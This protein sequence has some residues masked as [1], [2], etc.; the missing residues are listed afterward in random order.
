MLTRRKKYFQRNITIT[1]YYKNDN[2]QSQE[3]EKEQTVCYL[4][5]TLSP[6]PIIIKTLKFK[7]PFIDLKYFIRFYITYLLQ[8]AWD[9]CDTSKLFY[10]K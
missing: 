2:A 3:P 1:L 8:I 9:F 10:S 7:I 6:A 5:L 4:G